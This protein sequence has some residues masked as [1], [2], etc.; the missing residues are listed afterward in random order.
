MA[1]TALDR[2]ALYYP[3]IHIQD[4]NWLKS[5]LLCFPNIRR[6]VP[7]GFTPGDSDEIKEFCE[8][9]GP[10]GTPLLTSVDL[11][12]PSAI[13]AENA[14]LEC[15]QANDTFIRSRYSLN[16]TIKEY[17][18][19]AGLF[20][21]HDEK[22]VLV[23]Y[24]HLVGSGGGDALAWHT[25]PPPDRPNRPGGLWLGL[26]PTLGNAILALKA[27]A[28]ADEFG[29][30]IITDSSS[31]HHTFASRKPEDVFSELIGKPTE[32]S[33]PSLHDAVD[34]LVEIVMTTNFDASKMTARQISD[35]L[36]DGKDLRSFKNE[37]L[38]LAASIPAI[39]DVKEREKR[40]KEAADEVVEKWSKY[41][42]SLP[43]FALDA[44]SDALDIKWQDVLGGGSVY[45]IYGKAGL[46]LFLLS[47][48]G[49]K[50]WRKYKENVSNPYA[51]LNKIA[52]VQSKGQKS[53]LSL[54]PLL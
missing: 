8:I 24:N 48:A 25:S 5:A 53:F 45:A 36:S 41:K 7:H 44:L 29:L 26:H 49:V 2:D 16:A 46:G 50:V 13:S 1:G 15:L 28:L 19:S 38:P 17:G 4:V 42:K 6:M 18:T 33:V 40:F 43:G 34:D 47:H 35:L 39:K 31:I 30:D 14:L 32:S 22:I 52:K 10:R 21:L 3:H 9:V 11:F 27:F 20:A 51:Y 23:L 54:P 37:L 12:A